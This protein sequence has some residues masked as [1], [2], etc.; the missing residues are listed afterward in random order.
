MEENNTL[1]Q[2]LIDLSKAI[3][4]IRN[5]FTDPEHRVLLLLAQTQLLAVATDTEP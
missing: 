4:L 1:Q 3:A 2:H 5:E